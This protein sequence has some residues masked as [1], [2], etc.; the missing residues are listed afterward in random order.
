M[1]SVSYD[2]IFSNFLGNITDYDLQVNMSP[3]DSYS[4][5][6]EYLRKAVSDPYVKHIFASAVLDD[7]V[8]TLTYELVDAG[9][10][11][12]D[13]D[14]VIS[15]L[16]KWMVYEWLH[17]EVRS[18]LNTAQFFAGKEQK[19]YSQANHI[20]EL[21]ALQDDSYKEARDFIRDKGY[22]SNSYLKGV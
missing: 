6:A 12:S 15:A 3:S 13:K 2:E 9:D 8:Q 22:I 20:A 16:S 18:K 19:F 1:A 11:D 7:E 14:F 17:K 5:M 10:E 21:R 4:L